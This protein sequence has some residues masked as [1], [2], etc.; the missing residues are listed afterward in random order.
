MLTAATVSAAVPRV[1]PSN[2]AVIVSCARPGRRNRRGPRCL[3]R[4]GIDLE[5]AASSGFRESSSSSSSSWTS[6][7]R[8]RDAEIA[9]GKICLAS[10]RDDRRP[11]IDRILVASLLFFVFFVLFFSPSAGGIDVIVNGGHAGVTRSA[12]IRVVSRC[13]E[14][15]P[16][17]Y[18]LVFVSLLVFFCAW[19]HRLVMP[20][21]LVLASK[22]QSCR[23]IVTRHRF[24]AR[25]AFPRT[26]FPWGLWND[27]ET[28]SCLLCEFCGRGNPE[29]SGGVFA[30]SHDNEIYNVH[31]GVIL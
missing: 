27:P 31:F 11:T 4:R 5:V 17:S 1:S 15:R 9:G 8:A 18:S 25:R 26:S 20:V 12:R 23:V 22:E 24:L 14:K 29:N 3:V 6:R 28:G 19:L 2:P 16:S 30:Q 21:I 7:P 13:C 10:S